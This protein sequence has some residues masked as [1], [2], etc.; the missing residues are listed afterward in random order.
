MKQTSVAGV[1]GI[2][3]LLA[4]CGPSDEQQDLFAEE[5]AALNEEAEQ[6]S[7]S[8]SRERGSMAAAGDADDPGAAAATSVTLPDN[9]PDDVVLY[10][11]MELASVTG[12]SDTMMLQGAAEG[13]MATISSFYQR[14]MAAQGWV[15]ESDLTGAD[16]G[17]QRLRFAKED[18]AV[19][20][21]LTPSGD[22]IS[23]NIALSPRL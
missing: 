3:L 11:E 1:C 17:M 5:V 6:D 16:I 14:E 21:T 13:D 9:F 10:P 15:D 18:R 2:L 7:A 22:R 4:A 23:V 20:V 8:E 19:D 12:M